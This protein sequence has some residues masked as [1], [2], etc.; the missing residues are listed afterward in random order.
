MIA[1]DVGYAARMMRGR[2]TAPPG[3]LPVDIARGGG[4]LAFPERNYEQDTPV[5]PVAKGALLQTGAGGVLPIGSAAGAFAV[6]LRLPIDK[7]VTLLPNSFFGVLGN[8]VPSA[9]NS[10]SLRLF[11]VNY[12]NPASSRNVL[13][14]FQRSPTGGIA[15]VTSAPLSEDAALVV[16]TCNGANGWQLDWYSLE[17]GR[18]FEGEISVP[19]STVGSTSNG[20]FNIGRIGN[21]AAYTTNGSGVTMSDF[22]GEIAAIY[23][24]RQALTPQDWSEIALGAPLEGKVAGANVRYARVYDPETARLIRP[25]WATGDV[26]AACQPVEGDGGTVTGSTLVPGSH[27]RRQSLAAALT[28]DPLSSGWIYGLKHGEQ[29][30]DVPFSGTA[31]GYSGTVEVRVYEA[32]TGIVIKDWT[33]VGTLEGGRWSGKLRLPKAKG[34]WFAE[35]RPASAPEAVW[36]RRDHFAVGYKLLVVGQSTTEIPLNNGVIGLPLPDGLNASFLNLDVLGARATLAAGARARNMGR[37]G[38]RWTTDGKV[39]FLTQFRAF[40]PETPVMLVDECVNGTSIMTLISGQVDNGGAREDRQWADLTDKLD[41][42]GNDVTAV[43]F[44]WGEHESLGASD[45]AQGIEALFY[46][47]GPKASLYN[48]SSVLRPG[49]TAVTVSRQRMGDGSGATEAKAQA[50]LTWFQDRGFRWTPAISDNRLDVPERV[51]QAG[52]Y[53]TGCARFMQRLAVGALRG[54]NLD[55]SGDPFFANAR[56]A[57]GS[58][59]IDVIAANGGEIHSPT[60]TAL[61]NWMV[62][63]PG[64]A[65][66]QGTTS[67]RFTATLEG[68]RVI[69]RRS[70]GTWAANTQIWFVSGGEASVLMTEAEETAINDGVVYEQWPAD[71][72]G[73][74]LPVIGTRDA[75]GRWGVIFQVSVA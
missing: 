45:I 1:L 71:P 32:A 49:W 74:G 42:Y 54:L 37:I 66:W 44:N 5:A 11:P 35:A 22:P 17:T 28:M 39:A 61:R 69:L 30:C 25:S 23:A 73:V 46:G 10:F 14:Y 13:Q 56:R 57:G 63:E 15:N 38:P 16:A 55:A 18:R 51:H 34:W 75:Q 24:I 64:D 48:L 72:F 3:S 53:L 7:R 9:G 4:S 43:L 62:M 67:G 12:N 26:T 47:T 41:H 2:K 59:V 50:R 27:F 40:D 21:L 65:G 36:S 31:V 60:P 20:T 29:A 52:D 58:L 70:G 33:T 19:A 6:I 68:S 8:G